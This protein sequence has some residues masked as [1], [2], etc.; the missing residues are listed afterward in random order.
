[1]KA[2]AR[3]ACVA[4]VA[5]LLLC[6]CAS[7]SVKEEKWAP[8]QLAAPRAIVV[9]DYAT[10]DAALR[11]DRDGA[12][13]AAFKTEFSGAF[14]EMLVERLSAG[15]APARRLGDGPPPA[16]GEWMLEGEFTRVNQGSRLLRSLIGWGAGGTKLETRTLVYEQTGRRS[17]RLLGEIATTGGSNAEPGAL[18]LPTPVTAGVRLVLSASLTGLRPDMRRTTRMIAAALAGHLESRGHRLPGDAEEV[19]RPGEFSLAAP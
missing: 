12:E 1:V 5:S 2:A 15:V 18:G 10:P 7:V 9:D 11:V 3:Q 4:A 17:R 6:A 13:L 19:K 16:K 8:E 14:S